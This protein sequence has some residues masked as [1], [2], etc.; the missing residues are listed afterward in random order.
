MRILYRT[1]N[2]EKMEVV[3]FY[4][5]FCVK[6]YSTDAAESGSEESPD[7]EDV[8]ESLFEPWDI[9]DQPVQA[10]HT[11]T[12]DKE[13]CGPPHSSHALKKSSKGGKRVVE[14]SSQV[15]EQNFYHQHCLRVEVDIN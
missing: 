14:S 15:G 6:Y 10:A 13:S 7:M 3:V 12:M 11:H 2:I 5:C 8:D 9:E 4:F 1:H